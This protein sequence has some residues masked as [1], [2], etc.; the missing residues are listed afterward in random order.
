ML[1]DIENKTEEEDA[2]RFAMASTVPLQAMGEALDR[3]MM[4]VISLWDDVAVTPFIG[5]LS[6]TS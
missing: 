6:P 5:V 4:L 3:G 2:W 1:A